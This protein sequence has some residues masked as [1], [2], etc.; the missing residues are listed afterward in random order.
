M[1]VNGK[2]INI[3]YRKAEEIQRKTQKEME[4]LAKKIEEIHS[5]S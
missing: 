1:I 2:D 5:N 3:N 4:K